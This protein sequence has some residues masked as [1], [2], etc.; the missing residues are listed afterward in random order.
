[1]SRYDTGG[2]PIFYS[3]GEPA[4]MAMGSTF[5]VLDRSAI[6]WRT[7]KMGNYLLGD[8][9][10]SVLESPRFRLGLLL[11]SNSALSILTGANL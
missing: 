3:E 2:V 5:S 7:N 6:L 9:A 8:G 4:V 1:M 11:H 10:E